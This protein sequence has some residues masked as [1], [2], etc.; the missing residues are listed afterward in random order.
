MVTP[1]GGDRML[2]RREPG[3]ASRTSLVSVPGINHSWRRGSTEGSK[4]IVRAMRFDGFLG[5]VPG[6]PACSAFMMVSQTGAAPV[7]PETRCIASP[8]KFPTQTPTVYSLLK[9]MHQLSR[10]SLL[11]PVLTALQKRVTSGLSRPKVTARPARSL[12]ISATMKAASSLITRVGGSVVAWSCQI[13]K[14]L[15]IPPLARVR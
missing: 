15:Y 9:P 12:K 3:S 4:E 6:D 13:V 2:G 14:G 5:S 1:S 10:M 7:T 8:S 11:V